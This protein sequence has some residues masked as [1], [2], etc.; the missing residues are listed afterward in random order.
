MH[1][2]MP[3]QPRAFE[4]HY[5]RMESTAEEEEEEETETEDDGGDALEMHNNRVAFKG[6]LS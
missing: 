4:Y 1:S 3:I 2:K 5:Q 6:S